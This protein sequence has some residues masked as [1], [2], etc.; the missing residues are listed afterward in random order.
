MICAPVSRRQGSAAPVP[1]DTKA[2]QMSVLRRMGTDPLGLPA[3]RRGYCLK[4][5][6]IGPNPTCDPQSRTIAAEHSATKIGTADAGAY[7]FQPQCA[8]YN[9]FRN[10]PAEGH[11]SA[12]GM[13]HRQCVILPR[14]VPR[15][16]TSARDFGPLRGAPCRGDRGLVTKVRSLP[17][18]RGPG[19]SVEVAAAPGAWRGVGKC[20]GGNAGPIVAGK[21]ASATR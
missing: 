17:S 11:L 13:P 21:S 3:W 20:A 9:A 15:G 2:A 16:R 1:C 10:I 18:A 14:A 7:D 5:V 4:E 6:S 12:H 19:A 8:D